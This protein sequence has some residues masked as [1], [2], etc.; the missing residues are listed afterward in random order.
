MFI[1]KYLFP[2][3][4]GRQAPTAVENDGCPTNRRRGLT[5]ADGGK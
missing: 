5:A 4:G 2:P 1:E 3:V